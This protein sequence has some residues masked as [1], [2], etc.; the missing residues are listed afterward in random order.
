MV[1]TLDRCGGPVGGLDEVTR[2]SELSNNGGAGAS[3]KDRRGEDKKWKA[4]GQ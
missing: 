1:E 2:R 4:S 3:N